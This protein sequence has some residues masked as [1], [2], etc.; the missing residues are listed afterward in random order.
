MIGALAVNV[1]HGLTYVNRCLTQMDWRLFAC[2]MSA[3]LN[4]YYFSHCGGSPLCAKNGC[5]QPPQTASYS[6]ALA[7][8]TIFPEADGEGRAADHLV[9]VA[10][11]AKD[12]CPSTRA[13]P[14][15]RELSAGESGTRGAAAHPSRPIVNNFSRLRLVYQGLCRL[16]NDVRKALSGGAEK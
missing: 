16:G 4:R 7:A 8:F 3:F 10:P 11:S 9:L 5:E 14:R 12:T 2:G 1:N 13:T 6:T 15:A